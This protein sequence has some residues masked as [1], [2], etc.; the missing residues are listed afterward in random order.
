MSI[1]ER[2]I[3]LWFLHSCPIHVDAFSQAATVCTERTDLYM[4]SEYVW[5]TILS[6]IVLRLREFCSKMFGC[7]SSMDESKSSTYTIPQYTLDDI[8]SCSSYLLF[9]LA[10]HFPLANSWRYVVGNTW[11][12]TSWLAQTKDIREKYTTHNRDFNMKFYRSTNVCILL[13]NVSFPLSICHCPPF[14]P[15]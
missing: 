12:I 2:N 11:M 5:S 1:N 7:L 8:E 4:R 6:I 3:L 15:L 9:I 10:C 13:Q 14:H